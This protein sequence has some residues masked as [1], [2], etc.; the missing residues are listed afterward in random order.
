MAIGEEQPRT[1]STFA[2]ATVLGHPLD[3]ERFRRRLDFTSRRVERL[4]QRIVFPAVEITPPRWVVDPDFDL[5]YHLR[6]ASLPEPGGHEE[7]LRFVEPLLMSPLDRARPLWETYIVEGLAGG[8][9]A[10]VSRYSH[11]MFDGIGGLLALGRLF[12]QEPEP[13][14]RPMPLEPIPEDVT[15]TDLVRGALPNLPGTVVAGAGRSAWSVAGAGIHAVRHPRRTVADTATWAR[16]VTGL[17]GSSSVERSPLLR[18]RSPARRAL[19]LDVPL[20]SLQAAGRAVGGSVNDAYLAAVTGAM[21]AYHEALNSPIEAFPLAFPIS[22]R[23]EDDPEASNRW[24]AA[25][26]AAPA[27]IR[28]AGPRIVAIHELVAA[29]RQSASVDVIGRFTPLVSRLPRWAVSELAVA[30]TGTDVQASNVPGFP[31]QL[32]LAGAP[33]EAIYPFGP[34]PGVAVMVTL[35]SAN[36]TCHVGVNYDPASVTDGDEFAVCLREGFDEVLAVGVA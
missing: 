7:L 20:K 15:P 3:V 16:A 24:T 19:T 30:V 11:A 2:T 13:A 35:L 17:V 34:L 14:E 5:E 31:A 10:V 21:A 12:D 25:R 9:G 32:Y 27:G 26:L 23:T 6:Q 8:K 33:V 1:R 22:L 29:A 36:G 18:S 28:D 4:R